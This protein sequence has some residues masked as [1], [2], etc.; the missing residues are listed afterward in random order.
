MIDYLK[1]Y[2][3]EEDFN[4]INYNFKDVDVNNFRY[5]EQDIREVLE[6]LKSIG[7]FNFKDILLYRKDICLKNL[8]ILKEEVNKINKNLIVYLFNNDI[9]N[10][11][12]LNI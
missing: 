6:Y 3:T 7:V 11:I 10:L 4:V 1:E 2:I 12:N 9:S 8:D 5:Y